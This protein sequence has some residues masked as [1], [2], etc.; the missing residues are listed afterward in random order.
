M[1]TPG[2]IW[3]LL[4]TLVRLYSSFSLAYSANI[5]TV[6]DHVWLTLA[7][8]VKNCFLPA[9]VKVVNGFRQFKTGDDRQG[10][11]VFD[12]LGCILNGKNPDAW[13]VTMEGP[14]QGKEN[15]DHDIAELMRPEQKAIWNAAFGDRGGVVHTKQV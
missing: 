3:L 13:V 2:S 5:H 6:A 10:H 7:Q 15:F 8:S 4:N 9:L 1:V 12:A 14:D 11:D